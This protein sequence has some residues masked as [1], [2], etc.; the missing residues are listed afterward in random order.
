MYEDKWTIGNG[1]YVLC[2]Q[3]ACV[4][5]RILAAPLICLILYVAGLI[6]HAGMRHTLVRDCSERISL[7]GVTQLVVWEATA[8]EN[9]VSLD[10]D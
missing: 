6:K 9:G 10:S 3:I 5:L 2:F 1:Q 4:E 8:Q 7:T